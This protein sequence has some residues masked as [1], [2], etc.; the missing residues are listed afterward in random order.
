MKINLL[1]VDDESDS[2]LLFE[3]NFQE[4]IASSE[5]ELYYANSGEQALHI[6][7]LE[8]EQ[9]NLVIILSDINMPGMRGVVLL[10][11]IKHSHPNVT[12]FMVTDY[13]NYKDVILAWENGAEEIINKPV[14]FDYLRN[15][16]QDFI[17][18]H[19]SKKQGE[20]S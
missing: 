6:L 5:I 3:Q 2:T 18:A 14:N 19:N 10:K 11:E 8:K 9:P 7:D 1:I 17:R 20:G 12:I 15:L 16:I 4:E 13:G